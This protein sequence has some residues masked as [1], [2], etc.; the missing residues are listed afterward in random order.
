MMLNK[1]QN[2]VKCGATLLIL[3]TLYFVSFEVFLKIDFWWKESGEEDI[4]L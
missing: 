2:L 3:Q 1:A 4:V